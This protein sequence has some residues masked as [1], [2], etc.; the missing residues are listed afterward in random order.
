MKS[1]DDLIHFLLRASLCV[2][3]FLPLAGS[4]QA[5]TLV[6]QP[7]LQLATP[8]SIVIM[9]ETDDDDSSQVAWGTSE[10][11]GSVATGDSVAGSGDSKV[12]TVSLTGLTPASR[13]YYQVDGGTEDSEI[14]SF[15][16][17][18]QP[19]ANASFRMVAMSDMQ[20]DGSNPAKFQ[21]V[22]HDGVLDF[23]ESEYSD[24]LPAEL[25]FNLIP[26]DLVV[27]GTTYSQWAEHFF[28]PANPLFAEVPVYPVPGNHEYD[29]PNFF[30]Y[31]NLPDN[32]TTGYEEHWWHHQ[33]SNLLI[34]GLDSNGSYRIPEQLDW[35]ETTLAGVCNDPDIDFVFAQLHHPHKSELWTPGEASYTGDV[36][37]RMEDFTEECGKPSIHFFGHTHGYSRGQSRDQRHLWVNVAT[38]GGAIDGWGEYPQADYAEFSVSQD[39]WGFVFVEVEAGD[40]PEFTLRRVSRGNEATT[41]DNEVRDT[42]TVRTNS[43][44]PDLPEALYPSG[45]GQNPDELLLV[46]SFFA[47]ADSDAHGS[48]HFQLASSCTAFDTP[49]QE[50]WIQHENQYF[51]EDTLAGDDLTDHQLGYL[52]ANSAYCWRL[53]YRDQ[54]LAWSDWSEAT[55]FETGASA[56]SDN[57]LLNPGA[58]DGTAHWEVFVGT[59]ESLGDGECDSVTPYAGDKLFAVGGVCENEVDFGQSFQAVDLSKWATAIDAGE[60]TVLASAWMRNYSGSDRPGFFLNFF[61]AVDSNHADNL[62][63]TTESIG[64][65]SATW[66]EFLTE[67]PVPATTRR[68]DFTITGTRLAG[69]DNDSY[70]DNLSL[71]LSTGSPSSD[72]D[73]SAG[74]DD[75]DSAGN[76]DDDSATGDDDDSE[77]PPPGDTGALASSTGCPG[78]GLLAESR[79]DGSVGFLAALLLLTVYRRRR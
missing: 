54:A 64:S 26:G 79:P 12:H 58:E 55:A 65:Y 5:Q 60:L 51:G 32:G 38:A 11:L 35:L 20:R 40:N 72:D 1:A 22:V 24:D 19:S 77:A 46:G 39:D 36:I 29:S 6:V 69:S 70:L 10:T 66:T 47:D 63:E 75:D 30:R 8:E 76:D 48:T 31:F 44:P 53:R 56:F 68:V 73:D 49:L 23:V 13:Y 25:A 59:L 33:Y 74:N 61:D 42:I 3:A 45:S 52:S 41:R 67:V 9:W 62:V 17:P 21:E 15:I 78:C 28:G 14:Y 57:L 27:T 50:I 18:P 7:Y 34:V 2:L 16:T 71:Q 4:A 43:T 37:E